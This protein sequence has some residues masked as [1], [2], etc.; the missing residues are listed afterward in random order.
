MQNKEIKI[1]RKQE[2]KQDGEPTKPEKYYIPAVDIYEDA[3]AMTVLAEMPGVDKK[4]LE[5]HLENG[6]LTIKGDIRA[7]EQK[8]EKMIHREFDTGHYL[9]R[10][11]VTETVDQNRIKA[12]VTDG[13]L[14]VTL[15]KAK[16]VSPQKIEVSEG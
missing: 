11:T 9:R 4:D 14:T 1:Q 10:F 3:Q 13:I 6:V 7:A 8:N 12:T 15:P 16:P 5:V 2:V